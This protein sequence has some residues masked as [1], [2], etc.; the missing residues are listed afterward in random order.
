MSCET[1]GSELK[2]F[3]NGLDI[4]VG[5]ADIDMAKAGCEFRHFPPH[6]ETGTVPFDEPASRETAT[7]ILKSRPTTD[8]AA[9]S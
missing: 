5:V 1:F 6:V 3:R 8:P 7:K 9:P 2:K 4:P